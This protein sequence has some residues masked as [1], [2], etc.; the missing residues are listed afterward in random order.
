MRVKSSEDYY[1]DLAWLYGRTGLGDS[2][3]TPASSRP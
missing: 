1:A 3:K 2:G